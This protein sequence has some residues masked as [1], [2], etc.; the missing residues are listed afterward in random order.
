MPVRLVLAWKTL[1]K[2]LKDEAS[3][4]LM[5]LYQ[6]TPKKAC[7]VVLC[8]ELRTWLMPDF[9]QNLTAHA[10][11]GGFRPRF[12]YQTCLCTCMGVFKKRKGLKRLVIGVMR[13]YCCYQ[14]TMV[15]VKK[16]RAGAFFFRHHCPQSGCNNN[17]VFL[18]FNTMIDF[19]ALKFVS[20]NL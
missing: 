3:F 10:S 2:P 17:T 5:V 1:W 15:C 9:D 18:V 20:F 12:R 4:V 19:I 11:Y 14:I 7:E 8:V 13:E 6:E 16:H